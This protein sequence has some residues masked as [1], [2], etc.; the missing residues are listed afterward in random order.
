MTT[1]AKVAFPLL[2]ALTAYQA[3]AASLLTK[4]QAENIAAQSI[5]KTNETPDVSLSKIKEYFLFSILANRG[6]TSYCGV[7][8]RPTW[9]IGLSPDKTQGWRTGE[10]WNGGYP[11]LIDATTGEI[12]DCRS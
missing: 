9:V 3:H 5:Q 8:R 7:I 1:K 12:L 2:L 11:F 10:A 6:T 4:E